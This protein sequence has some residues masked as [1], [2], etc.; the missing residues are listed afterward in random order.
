M[1]YQAPPVPEEALAY[2][3]R[4]GKRLL[5]SF[6]YR[7]V[8]GEEHAYAFTVAKAMNLDVLSTIYQATERALA[9]GQTFEEFRRGLEPELVK[10]GWWGRKE[11]RDPVSGEVVDAQLGSPRRLKTIYRVNMR[12]AR[13]AGQWARAQAT[14]DV[15]PYFLYVL[16][17]SKERRS[18]HEAWAR[19]PTILPVDHPFWETRKPPNGWGCKCSVI[20][21]S[22]AE[23]RRRGGPTEAPAD[24][25]RT[26]VNKRT[27]EETTV[28]RGVDPAFAVNWGAVPQERRRVETAFSVVDRIA[29]V[30]GASASAEWREQLLADQTT[31]LRSVVAGFRAVL[32]AGTKTNPAKPITKGATIAVGMLDREVVEWI[33]RE[34]KIDLQ[35][36]AIKITDYSLVRMMR[37]AKSSRPGSPSLPD[38]DL[39]Q[40]PRRLAKPQAILWDSGEPVL[41]IEQ[42]ALVFVFAPSTKVKGETRLGKFVVRVEF[43][44]KGP[45]GG[46]FNWVRSGGLVLTRDLRAGRY[47]TIRGDL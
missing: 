45:G 37:P 47:E 40:L 26:Y 17:P 46:L 7:D 5:P 29:A 32:D 14:K 12:T 39:A 15:L 34:K 36:S 41:P 3:K 20:Q 22:E 25:L 16:S 18:E 21:I 13:S 10:Q 42:Q 28:P 35:T 2:L 1:T 33:V 38:E 43:D 4:R 8:W 19:R 11:M 27:R 30:V 24:D 23:A 44:S 31:N 6:D 9:E